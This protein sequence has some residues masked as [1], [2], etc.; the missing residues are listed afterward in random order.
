M[1]KKLK[2]GVLI[3]VISLSLAG[4][5]AIAQEDNQNLEEDQ[6]Q[7]KIQGAGWGAAFGAALGALMGDDKN[8]KLR[9][10]AIGAVIGAGAGFLL[11]NEVAKR[12]EQYA[13]Q[14]QALNGEIAKI[15]QSVREAQVKN[16]QLRQDIQTYQQQIA[17][18][19]QQINE[20][21]ASYFDLYDQKQVMQKRQE[22]A[23][24]SLT[25]LE[26]E[27]AIAQQLY[28]E[29]E[30]QS[31]PAEL[32]QWQTKLAKLEQEKFQLESSIDELT[33]MNSSL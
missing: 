7:T 26:K 8:D 10:A 25:E 28:K 16:Q 24:Q 21:K 22:S 31:T 20:G 17:Q 2:N 18:V 1:M 12:K 4:F 33:A 32:E 14:E 29:Y 23:E 6:T 19:Q 27:L 11:G 9:N 13:N 5:T 3:L 30:P 15:Q